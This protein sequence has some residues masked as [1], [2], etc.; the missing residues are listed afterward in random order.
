M[1][2]TKIVLIL[3]TACLA[4]ADQVTLKSGDK[5]TG[6]IIKKDGANL[7]M[8]SDA[9]GVITIPWAQVD[10]L[11]SAGPLT[12][13]L[14]DRTVQSTL[15]T[16]NG[17]V[18]VSGNPVAFADVT[19]IRNADEQKAVERLE[20]PG[21]GSLWAGTA[22]LNFAGTSGNSQTKS[23]V[24]TMNAARVTRTDKTSIYFTAVKSS[25][26]ISGVNTDT[27]QAV[28]GGVGYSR[29]LKPRLFVNLF[30][31]WEYDKFQDLDLRYVLGGGLGYHAWK[32]PRGFFDLVGGIDYAHDRF[33]AIPTSTPP[34]L[35]TTNSR[36]E[37]Y[38][39]DDFSYKLS[40]RTSFVQSWRMFHT[41]SD[42]GA[43]R[44]NFDAGANTQ[45]TKWLTWNIGLSDRYLAHPV[46]GR[47]NNDFIYSTGI[48]VTFA[49]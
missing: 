12:V 18:I 39:G 3:F 14:G 35:E 45:I 41:L 21:L 23:F 8:K 22:G 29:N 30:N 37:L 17:R 20:H 26:A 7:V 13:V 28:R 1:K 33:G 19:A 44:M 49:R 5:I 32:S 11:T 42:F 48:G 16:N 38:Y 43:Y 47:K 40:P 9:A 15:T 46:V 6:S 24:V 2:L 31:D 10:A 36:A 4:W 27:A 34:V 25:A